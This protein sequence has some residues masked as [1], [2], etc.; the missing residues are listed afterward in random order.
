MNH[1]IDN[2]TLMIFILLIVL[3]ILIFAFLFVEY[4][5]NSVCIP[6]M[7]NNKVEKMEQTEQHDQS[8]LSTQDRK[9]PYE[10][11]HSSSGL[12]QSYN[13]MYSYDDI[14]K[15]YDFRKAYDP[16]E[17]PAR[18]VARHEIHPLHL[19][20]LIDIPTRGYPDNFTQFGILVKEGNPNKNEDNKILRLYGRQ[21]FPGSNRYE[22]YTA[23]SSGNDIIKIPIEVRRQEL[24]DGDTVQIKE[25]KETYRVQ[26]HHFDM[27][28]Y[29]PDII[30]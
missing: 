8:N 4:Q 1:S 7:Q 2:R 16:F 22:Y 3:I 13:P 21:E 5:K 6:C 17:N 27:P 15:N 14:V 29:Y 12:I 23:I 20:R 18:R 10:A 30:Y 19:K 9:I 28:K 26:L 24:Y 11:L 25:L